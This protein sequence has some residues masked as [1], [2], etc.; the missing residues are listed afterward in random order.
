MGVVVELLGPPGA[1]KT[2]LAAAL[3]GELAARGHPV[4]PAVVVTDPTTPSAV[5]L[6]AKLELVLAALATRPAGSLRAIVAIVA[7]RQ[8]D[9]ATVA[10]RAVAWLVAQQLLARARHRTGTT[11]LDEGALQALWSLGLHGEHRQLLA[12]WRER[13]ARWHLSDLVVVLRPPLGRLEQRLAARDLPHSRIE[14]LAGE[15]RTAALRRADGLAAEI[16]ASLAT[17]GL[18]AER[19]LHIEQDDALAGAAVDHFARRIVELETAGTSS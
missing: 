7:S 19:V 8:P 12:T 6:L 9:A 5:R 18:A 3:R 16:G 13:P 11:I 2:T 1:G 10:H 15:E 14:L 4:A 17:L